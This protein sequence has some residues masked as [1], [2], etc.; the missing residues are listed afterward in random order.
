MFKG[1]LLSMV[2]L[3][4]ISFSTCVAEQ[5]KPGLAGTYF[6]ETDFTRPEH[7]VDYLDAVDKNW[8]KNKGSGWSAR[9]SG[10]IEGPFTGEVTFTAEVVNGIRLLVN[11]SVVIDGLEE[12]TKRSGKIVL[13]KGE[14]IPVIIEYICTSGN[15]RIRLFWAWNGRSRTLVPATALNH[16]STGVAATAKE[17]WPVS[18]PHVS[19]DEIPG[20]T[21]HACVFQH[22][23]IYDEPGR[24]AGWP[25]NGG[26]WVWGNEMAVAFESGWFKDKPDWEDGHARDYSRENEDIVARSL[27]GGLSWKY[28]QC[29]I[30]GG[31]DPVKPSPG[32]I[33]FSHPD[34]A[35]KLQG[36]R[37]YTSYDRARTWAGPFRLDVRGVP[38]TGGEIQA[39]TC[40][41]DG[42]G[43]ECRF[44][45]GFRPEGFEDLSCSIRTVD[46][47]KTF[48]L[49]GW[50]SPEPGLAPRDERWMVYS[51]VRLQNG[52]LV[53]ALRRKLNRSGG[54][55]RTL[56]WIDVYESKD[57]G[58]TWTFLS[59]VTNTT[60]P[61]TPYNGNPPSIV[62]LS[63]GRLCV[64]Y[65]FRGRPPTICA[66]LSS[67]GGLTWTKPVALRTGARNWDI[68]YSRSLQRG[69]GKVVTVY[70]F[71]TPEHRNQ[72]IEA[73]IWDPMRVGQ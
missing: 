19:P 48:E 66:R 7:T 43:S 51:A 6:R 33:D 71:A 4:A 18:I 3:I 44:F 34:F 59:K 60:E 41:L 72:F 46:G 17:G 42:K 8:G 68:G 69:D 14:R 32:G 64:T 22:V 49:E 73:T 58:R 10:Y 54:G 31:G 65:G 47:G 36:P 23:T 15:G 50:I 25:A 38:K 35:L 56:N 53:A 63:D 62:S 27:D 24:Y 57:N 5:L 45:I 67:D 28:T 61:N 39:R 29:P 37:F 21:E 11:G 26:L 55:V 70:Y 40:Y 52:H 12:T 20:V 16:D 30:L 13:K 1:I 9:W 2:S